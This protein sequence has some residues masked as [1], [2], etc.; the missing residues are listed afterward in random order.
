MCQHIHDGLKLVVRN[1][2]FD[3]DSE[4]DPPTL[5]RSKTAPPSQGGQ[6]HLD[7]DTD[8]EEQSVESDM[9]SVESPCSAASTALLSSGLMRTKTFDAFEHW[10][11]ACEMEPTLQDAACA[12]LPAPDALCREKTFDT[13]EH[14]ACQYACPYVPDLMPASSV[15]QQPQEEMLEVPLAADIAEQEQEWEALE[16]APQPFQPQTL[17]QWRSRKTGATFVYWTVDGRK[18][19]SN[20]RLTVSPLFKLP[21]GCE[22]VPPL[23]FKMIISP[24]VV[25]EGKGGAS[26]RKASGRAIIQLKCE[27]PCEGQTPISFNLSA[28]GGRQDQGFTAA[29]GPVTNNFAQSGVCGLPKDRETWDFSSLVDEDSQTFVVCLE[30]FGSASDSHS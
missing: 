24:L 21:S 23:P 13:F 6:A 26:F 2:F 7:S 11:L 14:Q 10:G 29:R 8:A 15:Q 25:S 19:R 20:D 3:V 16:L 30:V 27:A 22:D 12:V 1:T 4:L 9:E 28:G 5:Q 17:N 18:L